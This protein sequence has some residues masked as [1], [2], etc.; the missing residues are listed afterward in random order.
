MERTVNIKYRGVRLSITNLAHCIL[1]SVNT[2]HC[3]LC[4][5]DTKQCVLHTMYTRC[6]LNTTQCATCFSPISFLVCTSIL[7]LVNAMMDLR[8]ELTMRSL[9]QK[10]TLLL[11]LVGGRSDKVFLCAA[12]RYP[13]I[14]RLQDEIFSGENFNWKGGRFL[15]R[16]S[17]SQS[18]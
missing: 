3:V 4:I 6:T 2:A 7:L 16:L 15:E 18:V 9:F 8:S 17:Q 13:S 1:H 11:L 12:C 5:V 10:S 14:D